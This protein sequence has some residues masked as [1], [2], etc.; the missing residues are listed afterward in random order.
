[1]SSR[2]QGKAFRQA[3]LPLLLLV[4]GGFWGLSYILE[5][6]RSVKVVPS[7]SYHNTVASKIIPLICHKIASSVN[8]LLYEQLNDR[9]AVLLLCRVHRRERWPSGVIKSLQGKA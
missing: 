9:H 3:G 2:S 4:G 8:S 6:N 1:M 5:G 7:V